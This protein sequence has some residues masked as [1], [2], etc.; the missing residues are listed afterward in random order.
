MVY[1][2]PGPGLRSKLQSHP[3]PKLQQPWILNPL[4]WAQ[5]WTCIQVLPECCQFCCATAETLWGLV[6]GGGGLFFGGGIAAPAA[7]ME[8]PWLGDWIRATVVTYTVGSLNILCW[9]WDWTQ[10]VAVI[11]LTWATAET[12]TNELFKSVLFGGFSKIFLLLIPNSVEA[13]KCTFCD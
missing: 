11:F 9:A 2:V 10:A 5:N 13:R 12:P 7:C 4:C 6:G 8:V 1:G 3:K